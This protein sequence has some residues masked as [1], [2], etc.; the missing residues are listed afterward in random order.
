MKAIIVDIDGTL[1]HK[2]DRSPFDYSK[3]S[4]DKIDK[5]V[6]ELVQRLVCYY[7]IIVMSGR[8]NIC[9][10]D[11]EKWLNKYEIPY[12]MLMMRAENDHR[13]DIIVKKEMYESIK[14][15]HEVLFVLDDRDKV[16][17]MWRDLGL[18]CLQVEEGNF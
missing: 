15:I 5:P 12:N 13:D 18:K 1:A 10:E 14:G 4:N 9:Q 3:V 2:G 6:Q 17:K 11:T 16:V 7:Y 8:E